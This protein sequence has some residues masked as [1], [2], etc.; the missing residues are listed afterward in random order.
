MQRIAAFG[1]DL[2]VIERGAL[3]EHEIERG[4]DLVVDA[5][6]AFMALE[7]R[8]ARRRRRSSRASA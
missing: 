2:D 1:A 6:G 8:E 5:V 4:I 7:Q 3:A